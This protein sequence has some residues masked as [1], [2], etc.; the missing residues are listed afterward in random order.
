MEVLV[1]WAVPQMGEAFADHHQALA[2]A[3]RALESLR[4]G[5]LLGRGVLTAPIDHGV[6]QG[7]LRREVVVE[8][9]LADADPVRDLP[10]PSP[11]YPLR[12]EQAERD[13]EDLLSSPVV[14]LPGPRSRHTYRMIISGGADV[15]RVGAERCPRATRGRRA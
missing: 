15:N 6:D 2:Q 9:R 7:I 10:Q 8:S 3:L 11:F 14:P 13:P 5:R 1:F 4:D 12:G